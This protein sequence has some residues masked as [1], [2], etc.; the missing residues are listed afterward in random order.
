M[1]TSALWV[2]VVCVGLQ[3]EGVGPLYAQAEPPVAAQVVD[4]SAVE[5]PTGDEGAVEVETTVAT[6]T[7][8]VEAESSS[9][10]TEDT[11][12]MSP[13][14]MQA[15]R[16]GF[17][18]GLPFFGEQLM[19]PPQRSSAEVNNLPIAPFYELGTGDE[20]LITAWGSFDLSLR[21]L[22]NDQG[23]VVLPGDDRVYVEGL[24]FAQAKGLFLEKLRA[25]YAQAL[26]PEKLASGDVSFEVSLGKVRGIQV[27]M[28]GQ[29]VKPG[30][31]SFSRPLVL[32]TDV[33]AQAGGITGHGSLR[34]LRIQ[35]GKQSFD[36]DLYD[37]LTA[38]QTDVSRYLLHAGDVVTVPYRARVVSL[39]G[40]VK[41]P[42]IFELKTGETL[43]GLIEMA[44][45]LAAEAAKTR[46]Q[47]RRIDPQQGEILLDV[48][49]TRTPAKAVKLQDHD[50]VTVRAL[51]RG[52]RGKV[53]TVEGPGVLY[54]GTYEL[55]RETERLE[56]VLQ[57]VELY[58]D[59]VIERAL[60]IRVGP[61]FV[62]EKLV[63][64][65]DSARVAGFRLQSQDRLIISSAYQ[66]AG[67]DKQI[68]LS[69]HV[70]QPGTYALARDL[71]L[72][73][74]L[75]AFAGLGDLDYRSQTYL[76]R[77][78]V[79][80]LDKATGK[81]E[82]IPFRVAAVLQLDEDLALESNDEIRL[83]SV[84]RYRDRQTVRI[85][86]QVRLPEEYNLTLGMNLADLIAQ[87]G[88]LTD[89]ADTLQVEVVRLV[90]GRTPPAESF[91]V[92]LAQPDTFLLANLDMVFVRP[93][94]FLRRRESVWLRGE[95]AQP[96]HYAL[97]DYN[98]RLTSVLTDAGGLSEDAFPEGVRFTR[99]WGGE[100]RRMAMDLTKALEGDENNGIILQA[101]DEITI[102]SKNYAVAINGAVELPGLVQYL[103]GKNVRFY[104]D[105][106]GGYRQNAD[107]RRAYVHRAN[108]LVMKAT[109]RLWFDPHVPPG[110][111]IVVPEKGTG[112]PLWRNP[113][114]TGFVMGL[115]VASAGWYAGH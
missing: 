29:V 36:I 103:P 35:R 81:R 91:F 115:V 69:G 48:D 95:V 18:T 110:S 74:V 72:Y 105:N 98:E 25:T 34:A 68:T 78:D 99:Q 8:A 100:R 73:D 56:G 16:R 27:M 14:L 64:N 57:K 62:K 4:P 94:A 107:S 9:A 45:G 49:L 39:S 77:G 30:G 114:L 112:R 31:Y 44:G 86:G 88:G 108:G 15:L 46:V 26:T 22:V 75:F 60:L 5:S 79:L 87:A 24:T 101:G 90:Q 52:M 97:I 12:E 106:L 104:V 61:N 102:P 83:Y 71:T 33:L 54:P 111:T 28:V 109:R 58:E 41:R 82:L 65:L 76:E 43:A 93:K 51:P 37:L 3:M 92:S 40:Q 89:Q 80:R 67:G 96:G 7:E 59:A 19:Q 11:G 85:E 1:K 47:I 55:T 63:L 38:G 21:L 23:Y 32:L 66:L 53:V 70:K 13:A 42:A 17:P 10:A 50:Q 2:A 113:R 84:E 20:V 6:T